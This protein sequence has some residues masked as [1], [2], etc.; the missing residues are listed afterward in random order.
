MHAKRI[1]AAK[2]MSC[3]CIATSKYK[4]IN[5][6][7]FVFKLETNKS[8]LYKIK[9]TDVALVLGTCSQIVSHRLC[10]RYASGCAKIGLFTSTRHRLI[11]LIHNFKI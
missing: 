7:F 5:I 6:I 10:G 3:V 1:K 11:A 4:A 8:A 9:I 2:V